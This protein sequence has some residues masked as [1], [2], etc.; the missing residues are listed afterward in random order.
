[1]KYHFR[2]ASREDQKEV[3]VSQMYSKSVNEGINKG[4]ELRMKL[5]TNDPSLKS[6]IKYPTILMVKSSLKHNYTL[7]KAF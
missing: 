7:E 4:L 2:S 5:K 6:Y 1:M 3:T